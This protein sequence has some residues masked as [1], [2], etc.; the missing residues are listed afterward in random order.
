MASDSL[1]KIRQGLCC[2]VIVLLGAGF[3]ASQ[4]A[5]PEQVSVY[6]AK[7]D[8]PSI[9]ALVAVIFALAVGFAFIPERGIEE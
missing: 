3:V 2:L 4:L 5:Y 9:R 8:A 7:V 6:A 1:T